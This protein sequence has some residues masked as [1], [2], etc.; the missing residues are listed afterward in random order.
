MSTEFD[1]YAALA[2]RWHCER[3]LAKLH[4]IMMWYH[5]D[6]TGTNPDELKA[7]ELLKKAWG[8]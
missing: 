7:R 6:S 5:K 4:W 1:F 8:L 3:K 2:R